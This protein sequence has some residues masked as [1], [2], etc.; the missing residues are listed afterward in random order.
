M[1]GV[2]QCNN[3][4]SSC[5]NTGGPIHSQ[6]NPISVAPD[7]AILVSRKNGILVKLKRNLVFKDY[8]DTYS[9]DIDEI[10]GEELEVT[11]PIQRRQIQCI[12]LSPV[13]A[14]TTTNEVIRS[15]Q[16]G[17]PHLPLAPQI[18]NHPWPEPLET[19]VPQNLNHSLN[20]FTT[21]ISPVISLIR[22]R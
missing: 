10:D 3:T 2:Q 12:S 17:P 22:Q 19:Q 5:A 11:T 13:Q 1:G 7:V 21:G 20:T 15:P 16:P 4:T 8:F 14:I 6:G 18:C 9:E